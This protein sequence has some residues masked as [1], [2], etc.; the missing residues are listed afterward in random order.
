M[1]EPSKWATTQA[2]PGVRNEQELVSESA[3][4]IC[5]TTGGVRIKKSDQYQV[6]K[7]VV[8]QFD[9][10]SRLSCALSAAHIGSNYKTKEY[11]NNIVSGCWRRLA[12]QA[13]EMD[14]WYLYVEN[15][16]GWEAKCG[17][18]GSTSIIP[19]ARTNAS[20]LPT[21]LFRA[22]GSQH[23]TQKPL[24]QPL[25]GNSWRP[26]SLF[27]CNPLVCY[28]GRLSD[29]SALSPIVS[30]ILLRSF[31]F[32]FCPADTDLSVCGNS[33]R[34]IGGISSE[35]TAEDEGRIGPENNWLADLVPATVG[36]KRRRAV[37]AARSAISFHV[38]WF[39][40]SATEDGH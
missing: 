30:A 13:E 10:Q 3:S 16:Q 31:I 20:Q 32:P 4:A 5:G 27:F 40:S 1:Q 7:S 25:I 39:A 21:T 15:Q 9:P 11:L 22:G 28:V 38:T 24:L 37:T 12:A 35:V 17:S 34:P 14:C 18:A 2:E 29:E 23:E 36:A 19:A 6:W 8:N 26:P 33:S